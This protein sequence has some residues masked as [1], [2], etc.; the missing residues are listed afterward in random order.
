MVVTSVN[1]P[2]ETR[3]QGLEIR[4]PEIWKKP[5]SSPACDVWSLGVTV[6]SIVLIG[7]ILELIHMTVDALF[8]WKMHFWRG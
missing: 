3:F 6:G 7:C 4:A 1:I 8:G 5:Y 2:L